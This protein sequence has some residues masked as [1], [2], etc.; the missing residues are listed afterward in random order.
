MPI[1]VEWDTRFDDLIY[2]NIVLPWTWLDFHAGVDEALK[3]INGRTAT[4]FIVDV[5]K[6]GDFPPSGFLQHTRH[7]LQALP[8]YPMA[9]VANTPIL[10]V[11]LTPITRIVTIQR[12]FYFLSTIEQAR[13]TLQS[14]LT[15]PKN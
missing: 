8:H 5:R 12:Q 7:G 14:Q 13:K 1:T 6:A 3:L 2:V 15:H 9:F 11:V 4:G 10:K